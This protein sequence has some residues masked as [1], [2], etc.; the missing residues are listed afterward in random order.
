MTFELIVDDDGVILSIYF[1]GHK[2]ALHFDRPHV[3][4]WDPYTRCIKGIVGL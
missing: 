4:D 3:M 1:G 2:V